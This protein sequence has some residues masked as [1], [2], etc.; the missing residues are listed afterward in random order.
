MAD[1]WPESAPSPAVIETNIVTVRVPHAGA[2]LEHLAAAGVLAGTLAPGLL[3]FVT[4]SGI[5]D[6]G[7]ERAMQAIAT[8]P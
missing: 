2:V 5:D 6:P 3:R 4:H 7:L 1:R 8:A